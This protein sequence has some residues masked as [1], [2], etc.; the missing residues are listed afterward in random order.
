MQQVSFYALRSSKRTCMGMHTQAASTACSSQ[1]CCC[2]GAVWEHVT[3]CQ[4]TQP[5]WRVCE[6]ELSGLGLGGPLPALGKCSAVVKAVAHALPAGCN[7]SRTQ[8]QHCEVMSLIVINTTNVQLPA[9]WSCTMW[10]NAPASTACAN[11]WWVGFICTSRACKGSSG[12]RLG[13]CASGV[14][15]VLQPAIG[16][17]GP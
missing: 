10:G 6:L 5:E 15:Y 9:D 13:D 16:R 7:S 8:P 12:D 1:R 14:Y 11:G 17:Q 2:A 4:D 3:C